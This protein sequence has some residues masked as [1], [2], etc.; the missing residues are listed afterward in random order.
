MRRLLTLLAVLLCSRAVAGL[1]IVRDGKPAAV[2]V[3]ADKPSESAARAAAEL[4]HFVELMSGAKLP[5]CAGAER[6]AQKRSQILA[7]K[8][9]LERGLREPDQ[10]Y[11]ERLKSLPGAEGPLLPVQGLQ[12]VY[13]RMRR[14]DRRPVPDEVLCRAWGTGPFRWGEARPGG[15]D[16]PMVASPWQ[17]EVI[18]AVQRSP[19]SLGGAPIFPELR[20]TSLFPQIKEPI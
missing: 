4:Q 14:P 8:H 1:V 3:T 6:V 20:G 2:I 16:L 13:P 9:E 17:P 10:R 5:I 12:F 7:Y 18:K 15:P 19:E 11:W